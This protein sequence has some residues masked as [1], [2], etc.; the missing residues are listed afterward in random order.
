VAEGPQTVPEAAPPRTD[1][2]FS[3]RREHTGF[4]DQLA[5]CVQ[6]RRSQI[7]LGLDPDPARLWPEAL[8]LAGGTGSHPLGAAERAA[9]AV[10]AHCRLVLDAAAEQC[11][12]VKPQVA[13]FE[14]LGAP[15]W[16][17]LREVMDDAA[18][19]GLLVIAD[20]K[21]GDIDISARAYGQA[22]FGATATPFGEVQGLGADALTVSPLLGRD[23]LAPLIEAARE[24]GAGL[25]A[26][27]RTSNP[28]AADIQDRQLEGGG[29]VS[30]AVAR[31]IDELGAPGVGEAGLSDVGA[32]TGATAPERLETLRTL[33]PHAVWLLPGIGPQ[34]GSGRDL[35]PAFAP[36][37]AG[38]LVS[39]SRAIV[40]AFE[41]G[42]RGGAPAPCAREEA[43]RLRELIWGL[44]A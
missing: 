42:G 20:A 17:A 15:G 9:R 18:R 29:T 38:G 22:F 5:G 13:C 43:A 24:R 35:A 19:R 31:M 39:A 27:V 7:V 1:R 32:V 34:G 26:L 10:A 44:Y 3:G 28:G 12:A 11:V 30:E 25:F 8:E 23:S 16:A 2:P 33:M 14:R 36:G 6:R 37:P 40:Y 4:G 21:R 41:R